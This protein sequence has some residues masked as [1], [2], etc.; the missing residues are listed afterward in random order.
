MHYPACGLFYERLEAA[1]SSLFYFVKMKE[2]NNEGK[3]SDLKKK[4]K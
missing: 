3:E 1:T 2:K 4:R